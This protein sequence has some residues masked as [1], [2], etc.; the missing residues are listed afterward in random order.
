MGIL[1]S[2]YFIFDDETFYDYEDGDDDFENFHQPSLIEVINIYLR[3]FENFFSK[4]DY[5]TSSQNKEIE[6]NGA[7]ENQTED[8][9]KSS[10]NYF[11]NDYIKVVD[12]DEEHNYDVT[13]DF[14]DWKEQE[15]WTFSKVKFN[16]CFE[17]LSKI[18]RKKFL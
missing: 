8:N 7:S 6:N 4:V 18:V 12:N 11:K 16:F 2:K 15:L 10:E 3:S 13:N 14:E 17:K 5:R 9:Q 1:A